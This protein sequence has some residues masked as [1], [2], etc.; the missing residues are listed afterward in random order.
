MRFASQGA[1]ADGVVVAGDVSP[2]DDGHPEGG[3]RGL[4][5]FLT[6]GSFG[7]DLVQE[8]QAGG[9]FTQRWKLN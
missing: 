8:E 9:I 7:L 5:L 4:E 6:F 1:G 3:G 2:A